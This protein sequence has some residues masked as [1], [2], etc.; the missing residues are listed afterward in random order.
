MTPPPARRRDRPVHPAVALGFA[1]LAAGLLA[2][3]WTGEWRH[4]V[5]GLVALVVAAV[6]SGV[7]RQPRQAKAADDP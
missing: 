7:R 4:A 5:T 1:L 3:L 2:W 6:V